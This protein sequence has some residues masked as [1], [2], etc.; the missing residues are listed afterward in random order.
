MK[1]QNIDTCYAHTHTSWRTPKNGKH[2]FLGQSLK[3][4]C[5]TGTNIWMR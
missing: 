5:K 1:E 3:G 4:M 2:L